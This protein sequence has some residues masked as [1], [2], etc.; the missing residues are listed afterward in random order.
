MT[1]HGRRPR[2]RQEWPSGEPPH[3]QRLSAD[4]DAAVAGARSCLLVP[5]LES[6]GY[7]LRQKEAA[8]LP[9][10]WRTLHEWRVDW[11]FASR[12]RSLIWLDDKLEQR[13]RVEAALGSDLYLPRLLELRGPQLPSLAGVAGHPEPLVAKAG[14]GANSNAVRR[15]PEGAG[16]DLV[17]RI[18]EELLES[19]VEEIECWQL[20]EVPPGLIVEPRYAGVGDDGH[21]LELCVLCLWQRA[22]G[23]VFSWWPHAFW[24]DA[25]GLVW[26]LP[27]GTECPKKK[28]KD[29]C[30][31]DAY[32]Q[33]GRGGMEP[34]DAAWLQGLLDAA[35]WRRLA[36]VSAAVAALG[37]VEELRVDWFLGDQR[38]GPRINELT[39]MGGPRMLSRTA[40]GLFLR[41]TLAGWAARA[42]GECPTELQDRALWRR[43]QAQ[44]RAALGAGSRAEDPAD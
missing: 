42:G 12:P 4:V 24:V 37:Q 28:P 10:H 38:F 35:P 7:I 33:R 1:Q 31:C 18:A 41:G 20:Y 5:E 27:L 26:P 44:H 39:Y 21:P 29:R 14:H 36:E 43:L 23:A 6:W 2:H 16:E 30:P 13:R 15:V 40:G 19:C 9:G 8:D 11:T 3:R 32:R 25:A 22:V 34:P 17:S